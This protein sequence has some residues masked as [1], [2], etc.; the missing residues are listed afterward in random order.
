M[1]VYTPKP[2]FVPIA[3]SGCKLNCLHCMGR[4][5]KQM[6]QIYEA[7]KLLEFGKNYRGKGFLISGGFD[8]KGQLINLEKMLPAIERLSNKFYVAIHPGFLNEDIAA[9]AARACHIAFVDLPSKNAVKNVFRLN[10]SPYDYFHTMEMLL[11]R[12]ARVSPHITAGLNFGK[13]EE[14]EILDELKGYKV[15]KV[16]LNFILPTARTPFENVDIK[17]DEAVEFAKEAMKKFEDVA[18]GC[19]RPRKLDISLIKAGIKE[20]ANPSKEAMKY[21]MQK[22]I[23]FER[24]NYCCGIKD[25]DNIRKNICNQ[26]NE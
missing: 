19:M 23:K 15:E 21:I 12:G 8:E 2:N 18:I 26:G 10:A 4:Y 14:W 6:L 24:K 17:V 13:I 22:G 25:F 16:V 5:L 11:E 20:I 3:I 7:E 1:I 9:K